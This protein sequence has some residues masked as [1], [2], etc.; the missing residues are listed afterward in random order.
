MCFRPATAAVF[1]N[2]PNCDKKVNEVMGTF[3][4]VCPFCEADLTEVIAEMRAAASDA[5]AAAPDAS[6]PAAPGAP[7]AP[8]A[9][10]APSAPQAP[11]A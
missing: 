8:S 5:A 9:P 10:S 11:N 6:A 1:V 2:C 3:P 7:A 4:D